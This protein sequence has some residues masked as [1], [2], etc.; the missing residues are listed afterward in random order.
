MQII[1]QSV[2]A[3]NGA[4]FDL[5]EFL[6][7]PLFAHLAHES[8][9]GPRESPVWFHWD[10]SALWVIGGS[11]FPANLKRQPRCAVGIVDWDM[12][13]GRCQHVG[14]RGRAEVLQFDCVVARTI[15]R[16]YFGPD[17]SDWDPRFADVFTGELELELVRV[18]PETVVMRDQ[19]YKPGRWPATKSRGR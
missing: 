18:T 9:A 15:F 1:E 11:T 2:S 13:S 4:I 6:A 3:G 14:I 12:A 10:G 16:K 19:S 5:N 7:R 17:E 8:E